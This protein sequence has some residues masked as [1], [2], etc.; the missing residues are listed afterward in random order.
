MN[1]KRDELRPLD[2]GAILRSEARAG[3]P[4][5]KTDLSHADARRARLVEGNLDGAHLHKANLQESDLTGASLKGTDL[6]HANMQ[7]C[8][9]RKA[10][11]SRAKMEGTRL[12][13]SNLAE[14]CLRKAD[15]RGADLQRALCIHASFQ[16]AD[17]ERTNFSGCDLRWADFR[18][19]N[20]RGAVFRQATRLGAILNLQTLENS[21]WEPEGIDEWLKEGASFDPE[22]VSAEETR[23]GLHIR[24]Q[25][26]SD[27]QWWLHAA[28]ALYRIDSSI[29]ETNDGL[30]IA[31]AGDLFPLGEFLGAVAS[32]RHH[33]RKDELEQKVHPTQWRTIVDRLR[34]GA[35]LCLWE[36]VGMGVRLRDRWTHEDVSPEGE[37]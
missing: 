4:L 15:L 6:S 12:G 29:E 36:E 1:G 35:D 19:A 18:G 33:P 3:R 10:N 17:L 22:K 21:G 25:D 9:L 28:A 11:L 14:A 2:K 16:F 20:L 13:S 26:T 23:P 27:M 31:S 7:R 32:G 30:F 8:R 34:K 24:L 37:G 5:D